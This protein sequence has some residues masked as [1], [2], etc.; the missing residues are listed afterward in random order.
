MSVYKDEKTG[1]WFCTFRYKDFSG[2]NIQKKK[3]G[4]KTKREAKQYEEEF[5]LKMSGKAAD[6]TFHSLAEL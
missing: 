5:R 4:F 6:M 1:T 2:K 3:R